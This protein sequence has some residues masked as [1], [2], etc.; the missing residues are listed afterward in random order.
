M[1]D[2]GWAMVARGSLASLGRTWLSWIHGT[3]SVLLIGRKV[4][5]CLR[6]LEKAIQAQVF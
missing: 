6:A 5:V 4:I 2:G 3:K 1:K